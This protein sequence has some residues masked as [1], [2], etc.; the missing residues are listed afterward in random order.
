MGERRVRN[1]EVEGSIPFKSTKKC[2]E[3]IDFTALLH[4]SGH[5]IFRTLFARLGAAA[6]STPKGSHPNL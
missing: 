2:R 5:F 3:I 6:H 1:A 4:F